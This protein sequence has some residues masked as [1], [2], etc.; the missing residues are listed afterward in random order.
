[1][2]TVK[3][4]NIQDLPSFWFTEDLEWDVN[5]HALIYL[6]DPNKLGSSGGQ[7]NAN[8]LGAFGCIVATHKGYQK[9]SETRTFDVLW[10]I[11]DIS[12]I[13]GDI[14]NQQYD[15]LIHDMIIDYDPRVKIDPHNTDALIYKNSKNSTRQLSFE[16]ILNYLNILFNKGIH[17]IVYPPHTRQLQ[18]IKDRVNFNK[19]N[20]DK[21]LIL[22]VESLHTRF[23]KDK[24]NYQGIMP[25]TELVVDFSGYFATF[26]IISEF[27]PE[28]DYA[29]Q[30]R[31][32]GTEDIVNDIIAAKEKGMRPWLLLSTYNDELSDRIDLLKLFRNVNIEFIIDEV[33]YQAWK[34]VEL[35][36]K[37]LENVIA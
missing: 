5:K 36:K 25:E 9:R 37:A 17:K 13:K 12:K 23:G 14:K 2:K 15:K 11:I 30:T 26:Q 21:D 3:N 34:Q 19:Q 4:R 29:V 10:G 1:M 31:G 6:L 8:E 16:E 35:I 28:I 27:N 33:D 7:E 20:L 24:T 22:N 32:R 18:I